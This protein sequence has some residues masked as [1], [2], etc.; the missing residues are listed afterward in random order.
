MRDLQPL[1]TWTAF[2]PKVPRLSSGDSVH[3]T[4]SAYTHARNWRLAPAVHR[5]YKWERPV[6][7]GCRE[8]LLPSTVNAFH[9]L[10]EAL[11]S[12]HLTLQH[13]QRKAYPLRRNRNEESHHHV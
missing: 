12:K 3:N 9:L 10:H 7:A 13:E 8:Q 1:R 2:S 5:R 11:T 4:L 6:G